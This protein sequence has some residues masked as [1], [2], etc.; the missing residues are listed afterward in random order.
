MQTIRGIVLPI[1]LG[2]VAG[3][4]MGVVVHG[5]WAVIQ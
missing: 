4:I 1:A 5:L 2:A 3:G